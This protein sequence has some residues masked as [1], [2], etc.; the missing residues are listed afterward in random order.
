M[1]GS[2]GAW[3]DGGVVGG[4]RVDFKSS[5][6]ILLRDGGHLGLPDYTAY[7]GEK[8]GSGQLECSVFSNECGHQRRVSGVG[9]GGCGFTMNKLLQQSELREIYEKVEAAQRITDDECL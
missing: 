3:S 2:R 9:G 7:F 4:F 6:A 5:R 8:T 1:R